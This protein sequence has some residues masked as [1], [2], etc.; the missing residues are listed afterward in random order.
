MAASRFES[1]NVTGR[2]FLFTTLG[3]LG[4]LHPYIAV[5]L[6]LRALGHAVTIATSEVY[7]TKIEGE[8]L[9]FAPIRPDFGDLLENP[10]A[11]AELVHPW[12]GT[13]YVF[14]KLILP[15]IEQSFE[16]TVAA[17]KDADLIAGHPI[18]F[19]TPTVA[20]YLKKPWTSVALQPA[21][22]LSTSDPPALPGFG[23]LPRALARPFFAFARSIMRHWG[24]PVNSLRA[25]LG[26]RPLRDPLLDGMF[27]PHGTHAWF[28]RLLATPQPDWPGCTTV[29]GF[30]FYD[31]LQPAL[32]MAPELDR[33]LSSG[34]PPVVFTLGS[35]AVFDAG[36]FYSESFEAIRRT[37]RRAVFLI[38]RD[39]RNK[40]A[41]A[42]PESVFA[43]EYAPYSELLPRAAA[44]V[45]QGGIG[46]TAQA[47]RA[48][49]P[50]IVVPWSHDQ[51][52]NAM[53]VERL[54]VARVIP[55]RQYRAKRLI[56][57][58][59]ELLAVE[60]YSASAREASA[61]IAREDGVS[62]ACDALEFCVTTGSVQSR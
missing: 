11:I 25:R 18:A 30:P 28:S 27:S 53:R 56:R 17:A 5:G 26:L 10:E 2:H 50:M 55:R 38:G 13:E 52:D 14:R 36:V 24:A 6:G 7:R 12:R 37:G 40:P 3:S 33:F 44:T 34:P 45:H 15:W 59:E 54:G 46:T 60:S 32:G 8:G 42:L 19:A 39:P 48:A 47:L 29:T 35:S 49:R 9:G 23:S 22:F 1:G 16:D 61:C 41:D 62:Q 31:K 58:L 4:D 57:E 51:P 20:E 21:I 43:A